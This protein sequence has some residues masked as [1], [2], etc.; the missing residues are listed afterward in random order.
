MPEPRAIAALEAFL[1][2]HWAKEGGH[3]MF[4]E[5]QPKTARNTTHPGF[6][7]YFFFL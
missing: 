7:G 2:Q 5:N 6:L 3:G 1:F 4:A